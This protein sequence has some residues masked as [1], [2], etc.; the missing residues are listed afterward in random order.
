MVGAKYKKAVM[1][2]SDSVTSASF[3]ERR[4]MLVC[5]LYTA[6]TEHGRGLDNC[7]AGQQQFD[8]KRVAKHV[9]IVPFCGIVLSRLRVKWRSLVIAH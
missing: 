5:D 3:Y 2:F 4:K 1:H 6:L 9:G 8:R 7:Y